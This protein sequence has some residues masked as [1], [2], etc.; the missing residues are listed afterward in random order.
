MIVTEGRRLENNKVSVCI[1]GLSTEL[2]RTLEKVLMV[3]ANQNLCN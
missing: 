2:S 3:G 1:I